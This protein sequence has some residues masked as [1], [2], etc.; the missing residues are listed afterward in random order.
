MNFIRLE[1]CIHI[2]SVMIE[3]QFRNQI[4]GYPAQMKKGYYAVLNESESEYLFSLYPERQ[5]NVTVMQDRTM[6]IYNLLKERKFDTILWTFR[7]DLL[8]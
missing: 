7:D 5:R 3:R 8:W 2:A 4:H 1:G 6:T